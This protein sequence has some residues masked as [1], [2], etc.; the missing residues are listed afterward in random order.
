MQPAFS[1]PS[2]LPWGLGF[3][4]INHSFSRLLFFF[5]SLETVQVLHTVPALFACQNWSY[6]LCCANG[7][8][9]F[10]SV[11][12]ILW[13]WLEQLSLYYLDTICQGG[14]G[15]K[16]TSVWFFFWGPFGCPWGANP[17]QAGS[18]H[19]LQGTDS[20][21]WGRCYH[22]CLSH[23][24]KIT[25]GECKQLFIPRILPVCLRNL[26]AVH[27]R[28]A[29]LLVM[30]ALHGAC[31]LCAGLCLAG[32]RRNRLEPF[33]LIWREGQENPVKVKQYNLQTQ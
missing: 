19:W 6:R 8:P 1:W 25:T 14:N 21:L 29:A 15:F 7:L 3:C 10:I 4:L 24:Q 28:A 12:I 26:L 23:A 18:S 32:K 2:D 31:R 30:P 17:E 16:S 22:S 20:H 5:F 13:H 9:C 11:L 27:F 33:Q